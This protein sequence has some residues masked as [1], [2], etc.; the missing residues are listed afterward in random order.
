MLL[1][2]KTSVAMV[3]KKQGSRSAIAKDPFDVVN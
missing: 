3:D 2:L 1:T